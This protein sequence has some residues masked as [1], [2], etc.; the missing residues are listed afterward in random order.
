MTRTLTLSIDTFSLT[1]GDRISSRFAQG[2]YERVISSTGEVEYSLFGSPVSDGSLYEAK[3]VWT[4]QTYVGIEQWRVLWAIF[5]RAERHRRN[6]Q[7]SQIY[8][9]DTIQPY[10]EDAIAPTRQTAGDITPIDGGGIA[11]PAVY[12][13]R[14]FEPK[15]EETANLQYRYLARFVLKELDRVVA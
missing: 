1:L 15:A 10:I 6:Q 5:A 9:S 7:D 2:G 11:Y 13:V 3:F 14:M 12:A 8:L 4:I